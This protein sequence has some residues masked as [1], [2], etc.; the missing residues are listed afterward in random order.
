M[1]KVLKDGL[2]FNSMSK[3]EMLLYLGFEI[4]FDGRQP[5]RGSREVADAIVQTFNDANIEATHKYDG[6]LDNGREVV[7][8]PCTLSVFEANRQALA[9]AFRILQRSG[10][11]NDNNR[12]GG[13]I[14]I[15]KRTLGKSH[16][17]RQANLDKIIQWFINN[18]DDIFKYTGRTRRS[19]DNWSA[20]FDTHQGDR[21]RYQ[22]INVCNRHTVEFRIFNAPISVTDFLANAQLVKAIVETTKSRHIDIMDLTLDELITKYKRKYKE[23]YTYWKSL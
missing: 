13:H 15:S 6:S 21:N 9:R 7:L 17:T 4:E 14:H 16:E 12:A 1:I 19:F 2:V 5:N 18:K 22:A 11:V 23:L 20:I 10:F 8:H 3:K